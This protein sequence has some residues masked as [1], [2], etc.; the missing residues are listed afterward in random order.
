M[1]ASELF[2]L[3]GKTALITGS[4]RGIGAGIAALMADAG[5]TVWI[6]GRDLDRAQAVA[7]TLKGAQAVV[8][9]VSDAASVKAA[10]S[11]LRKQAGQLDVLVNN[12]GIMHPAMIAMTREDDLDAMMQTNIKGAFLCAQLASRL[13]SAKKSGSI[14]NVASI[15]GAQGAAGFSAYAATKAAVIGMTRAMAKEM[16]PHN[17]RVNALAP[18]FI[19][20]DLTADIEGDARESALAGIGMGRFGTVADVAAAALFLAA[21]ASA[22]VTGQVLGVDGAMQA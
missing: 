2:D 8:L 21:P 16:A 17:V 11:G 3:T 5:A 14:I 20:T 19:E 18:G 13:M 15:M 22:Y 1:S 9:D 6:A 12:A 4:T 7:D 10:I